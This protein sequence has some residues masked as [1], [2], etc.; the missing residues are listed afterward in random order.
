[1]E[2]MVKIWGMSRKFCSNS[3]TNWVLRQRNGIQPNGCE[4]SHQRPILQLHLQRFLESFFGQDSGLSSGRKNDPRLLLIWCEKHRFQHRFNI[5]SMV[6]SHVH[7]HPV[8][9][10]WWFLAPLRCRPGRTTPRCLC[11]NTWPGVN[12]SKWLASPT[13]ESKVG[14]GGCRPRKS[15][16]RLKSWL[17][18]MVFHDVLK[19]F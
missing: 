12:G 19:V 14:Q 8:H 17:F 7:F 11:C 9:Q 6:P 5:V 15:I 16:G 18:E 3:G 4:E 10:L 13:A 2:I 1:M